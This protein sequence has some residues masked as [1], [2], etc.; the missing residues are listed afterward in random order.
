MRAILFHAI[1][2]ELDIRQLFEASQWT[3]RS[4]TKA[5]KE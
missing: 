1:D 5:W 4:M 3:F 2:F